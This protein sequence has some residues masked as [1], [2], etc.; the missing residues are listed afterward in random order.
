MEEKYIELINK[1]IDGA[2][3]DRESDVLQEYLSTNADGRLLKEDLS[4]ITHLLASVEGVDPPS[5]LKKR[6]LNSIQA[7]SNRG[8]VAAGGFKMSVRALIFGA[9]PVYAFLFA[10]GL[11]LGIIGYALISENLHRVAPYDGSELTG[12]MIVNG[13]PSNF[14]PG[15]SVPINVGQVAG[16]VSLKSSKNVIWAELKLKTDR[17]VDVMLEYPGNEVSFNGFGQSIQASNS[18]NIESGRLQLRHT[19]DNAYIFLLNRRTEVPTPLHVEIS[20]SG[21]LLFQKTISTMRSE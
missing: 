8:A 1:D 16:N 7:N 20:S 18:L 9:K 14:E 15:E 11:I 10:A 6:I 13:G 5:N 17:N 2:L 12:T 4:Q 21:V 3:S 19:G